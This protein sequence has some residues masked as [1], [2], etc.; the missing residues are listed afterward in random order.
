MRLVDERSSRRSSLS[1]FFSPIRHHEQAV[2]KRAQSLHAQSTRANSILLH[3]SATH[4]NLEDS[5]TNT[6][7]KKSISKLSISAPLPASSSLTGPTRLDT[8]F[9]SSLKQPQSSFIKTR[10]HEE[11]PSST[12][13]KVQFVEP[14]SLHRHRENHHTS[15]SV[16]ESSLL[17]SNAPVCPTSSVYR[18]IAPTKNRTVARISIST[19]KLYYIQEPIPEY[20]FPS[21]CFSPPP[22][23]SRSYARHH[24]RHS[25]SFNFTFRRTSQHHKHTSL[26]GVCSHLRQQSVTSGL[27]YDCPIQDHD[28]CGCGELQRDS[29]SSSTS[30][31]SSTA[32]SQRH[33]YHDRE[34]ESTPLYTSASEKFHAHWGMFAFNMRFGMFRAQDRMKDGVAWMEG[35]VRRMKTGR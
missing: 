5:K 2:R 32:Q 18:R 25:H 3:D 6:L 29:G 20:P 10:H 28:G 19:G 14:Q 15:I 26:A 22:S 12:E 23:P 34:G 7:D 1:Q 35:V 21:T 13:R 11:P 16:D 24:R 31:P 17:L 33:H 27:H 4:N 9:A 30:T 8:E